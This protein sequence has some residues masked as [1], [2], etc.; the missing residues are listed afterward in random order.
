MAT[1]S[2]PVP[3]SPVDGL[4]RLRLADDLEAPT[5]PPAGGLRLRDEDRL[6]EAVPDRDE[7]PIPIRRLLEEVEGAE[8]RGLDRGLH[9]PVPRDHDADE[10]GMRLLDALEQL[11]AVHSR[12]LDVEEREI[13][14]PVGK[15]VQRG[16][17]AL[18]GAN[19]VILVLEDAL[20]RAANRGVVV[21]DEDAG[22]AHGNPSSARDAERWRVGRRP[23]TVKTGPRDALTRAS[24]GVS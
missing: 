13:E 24:D 9:R 2:L 20:E 5:E 6:L 11:Q 1:S 22:L 23:G 15:R 3:F 18:R 7:E 19:V 4:D 17:A 14:A 8:L 10:V 12:H 16:L 21:D